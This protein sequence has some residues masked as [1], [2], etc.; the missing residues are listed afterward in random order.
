MFIAVVEG[1]LLSS[2]QPTCLKV[3]YSNNFLLSCQ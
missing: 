1:Q 3:T 2:P